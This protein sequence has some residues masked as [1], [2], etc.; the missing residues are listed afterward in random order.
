MLSDKHAAADEVCP[1]SDEL[2]GELY[3][4]SRVG[5]PVLGA[6]VPPDVRASL[7]IFCYRRSHLHEVGLAI[8]ATCDEEDLVKL[9]GMARAA[10]FARSRT[11]LNPS[12]DAHTHRIGERSLWRPA[13]SG[14]SLP[15]LTTRQRQSS[16]TLRRNVMAVAR[17]FQRAERGPTIRSEPSQTGRLQPDGI[18]GNRPL[19]YM[20]VMCRRVI[21]AKDPRMKH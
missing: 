10:L 13:A 17:R 16:A 18:A 21:Q 3:R 9:G 5:L 6:A 19:T 15:S 2:L 4:A 7:A 11:K 20:V 1:I 12:L 8:A 14:T